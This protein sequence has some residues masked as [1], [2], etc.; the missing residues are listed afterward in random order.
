MCTV[1]CLKKNPP[2]SLK[3]IFF[4]PEVRQV[5]V[6]RQK[7]L[8]FFSLNWGKLIMIIV[9]WELTNLNKEK[10]GLFIPPQFFKN[11]FSLKKI[12][13]LHLIFNV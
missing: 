7:N 3:K 13:N 10:N 4:S 6:Q 1:Y 5:F 2:P 8:G 9:Q 12:M 11:H